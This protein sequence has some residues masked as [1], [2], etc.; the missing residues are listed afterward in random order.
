VGLRIFARTATASTEMLRYTTLSNRPSEEDT[1]HLTVGTWA[2]RV[3]R[4][5][6]ATGFTSLDHRSAYT[7]V[8]M[9]SLDTQDT[10]DRTVK[11]C[12]SLSILMITTQ[13]MSVH[14]PGIYLHHLTHLTHVSRPALCSHQGVLQ[15]RKPAVAFVQDFPFLGLRLSSANTITFRQ[16]RSWRMRAADIEIYQLVSIQYTH[17]LPFISSSAASVQFSVY[18]LPLKFFP[19]CRT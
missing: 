10:Q 17:L 19:P 8:I 13:T 6:W 18:E 16:G 2:C 12:L 7:V 15:G 5:D 14:Q 4:M 3:T 1:G 11:D 9:D